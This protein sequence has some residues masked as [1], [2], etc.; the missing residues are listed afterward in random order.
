MEPPGLAI[1]PRPDVVGFRRL[2]WT[3]IVVFVSIVKDGKNDRTLT[4]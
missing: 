3:G 4:P 2:V 1:L